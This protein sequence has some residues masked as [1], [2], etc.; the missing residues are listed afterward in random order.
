[1]LAAACRASLPP[2]VWIRGPCVAL[3]RY[4][5]S[6][7]KAL[8]SRYQL[9]VFMQSSYLCR[10]IS[11]LGFEL[12]MQILSLI[13]FLSMTASHKSRCAAAAC[14]VLLTACHAGPTHPLCLF[15]SNDSFVIWALHFERRIQTT[16]LHRTSCRASIVRQKSFLAWSTQQHWTCGA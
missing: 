1:M 2:L 5:I 3:C 4:L 10:C 8:A 13:T 15:V 12:C 11:L 9:F 14:C 16:R 6:L 7:V